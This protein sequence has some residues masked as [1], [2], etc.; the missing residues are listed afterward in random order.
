M[1]NVLSTEV[2]AQSIIR[3]IILIAL[4][5]SNRGKSLMDVNQIIV[6]TREKE[7][8]RLTQLKKKS[9]C[10]LRKSKREVYRAKRNIWIRYGAFL[11]FPIIN[12]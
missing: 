5:K 4:R 12:I 2:M 11:C 3:M 8:D 10:F 6:S 9:D 1:E 7:N